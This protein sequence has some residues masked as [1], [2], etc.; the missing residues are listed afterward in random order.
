MLHHDDMVG[1]YGKRKRGAS[2]TSR[3]FTKR[4]R[5]S[6]Y[7][8]RGLTK[9]GR[10]YA[11]RKS[12][13]PSRLRGS[14][15]Q[16][17]LNRAVGQV[18]NGLAENKVVAVTQR[19]EYAPSPIQVLAKAH[20]AGFVIGGI[21]LGWD[22][23]LSNIGGTTIPP[24]NGQ[25]QRNGDSVYMRKTRLT[26]EIDAQPVGSDQQPVPKEYRMIIVKQNR[27]MIPT[28]VNP[29]PQTSL[30]LNTSG[31][32]FG[33]QTSGF[34]GADAM[35]QPINRKYWT[36]FK[37]MRFRLTNPALYNEAGS[38]ASWNWTNQN[39]GS[40]KRVTCDLPYYS[41]CSFNSSDIPENLDCHYAVFIFA[42]SIGQDFA[43]DDW[44][45]NVRGTTSYKDM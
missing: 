27:K 6:G 40:T 36:V 24:G 16:Y 14:R 42:R 10:K 37:D 13:L 18:L 15:I 38:A 20:Y 29:H 32:E 35:L 23:N 30:F 4:G 17:S 41:K 44:E 8:R 31:Q 21:P 25:N 7:A 2:G 12:S 9:Y 26:F 34:T 45:V 39:Y 11:F 22:S 19:D 28:G 1:T 33:Y 3:V 5:M 43:A